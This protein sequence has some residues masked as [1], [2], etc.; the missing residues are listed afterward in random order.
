MMVAVNMKRFLTFVLFIFFAFLDVSLSDPMILETEFGSGS[1]PQGTSV[2]VGAEI[3]RF[4]EIIPGKAYAGSYLFPAQEGQM[5]YAIGIGDK[6]FKLI[7][8]IRDW[9][10][11]KPYK[12]FK[13]T[14]LHSVSVTV[15]PEEGDGKKFTFSNVKFT[16]QDDMVVRFPL[17]SQNELSPY[18]EGDFMKLTINVQYTKPEEK[19]REKEP[20]K[21]PAWKIVVP[22]V[23]VLTV[24]AIAVGFV[25]RR[26]M[27]NR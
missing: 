22:I 20:G 14:M 3:H 15:T 7:L 5:K 25:V 17:L 4:S 6:Q 9:R 2:Y 16:Q 26:R 27:M 10:T 19:G 18:N 21:T 8:L 13:D 24:V 12:N 23:V 1:G 11:N